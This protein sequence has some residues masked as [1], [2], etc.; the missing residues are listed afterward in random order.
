[1][2]KLS[3]K[4]SLTLI[5]KISRK[6]IEKCKSIYWVINC[7]A[8]VIQC[9]NSVLQLFIFSQVMIENHTLAQTWACVFWPQLAIFGLIGLKSFH[10][11]WGDDDLSISDKKSKLFLANKW[12]CPAIPHAPNGLRPPNPTEKLPTRWTF[13]VNCYL[14]IMFSKISGVDPP[15]RP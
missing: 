13:W 12:A 15:P 3:S 9:Y 14:E 6:K 1:M 5:L 11:S 7:R 8:H 2:S 4:F 10:G